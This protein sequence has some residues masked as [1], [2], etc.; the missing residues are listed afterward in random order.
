MLWERAMQK[1]AL[2]IDVHIP[3]CPGRCVYC[4]EKSFGQNLGACCCT[5]PYLVGKHL[6]TGE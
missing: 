3:F 2:L 6:G 5:L 1:D 4:E